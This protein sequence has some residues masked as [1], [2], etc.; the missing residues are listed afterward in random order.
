VSLSSQELQGEREDVSKGR[1]IGT[2]HAHE[3]LGLTRAE[4]KQKEKDY[5]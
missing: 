3:Y 2:A 5:I 4:K 1:F